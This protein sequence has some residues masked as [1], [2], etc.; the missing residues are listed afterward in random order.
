MKIVLIVLLSATI[1]SSS[2]ISGY[3]LKNRFDHRNNDSPKLM[4]S[5]L[6]KK[7]VKIETDSSQSQSRFKEVAANEIP[8]NLETPVIR[9]SK[10]SQL[11]SV[12]SNYISPGQVDSLGFGPRYNVDRRVAQKFQSSI[13][14]K[15]QYDILYPTHQSYYDKDKR[16]FVLDNHFYETEKYLLNEFQDAIKKG[17]EWQPDLIHVDDYNKKQNP[18]KLENVPKFNPDAVK[19]S[20][21]YGEMAK[22]NTDVLRAA[23]D[24]YSDIFG[25]RN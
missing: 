11:T 23:S 8:S 6:F 1:L 20:L 22:E 7:P 4:D 25:S 3:N 15:D 17:V 14:N 16:Y 13:Y 12:P 18:I 2:V 19:T 10:D 9:R 5:V 24:P 21:N